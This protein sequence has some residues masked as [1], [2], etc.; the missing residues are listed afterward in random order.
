VTYNLCLLFSVAGLP[1]V[2]SKNLDAEGRNTDLIHVLKVIHHAASCI[3]VC[4]RS[5]AVGNNFST[6]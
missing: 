4:K 5:V 2:E 3:L 1:I 6:A